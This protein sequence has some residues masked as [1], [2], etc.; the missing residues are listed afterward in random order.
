MDESQTRL[1]EQL[2]AHTSKRELPAA[3]VVRARGAVVRRRARRRQ[4]A[5]A[6]G[7]LCVALVVPLLV[8][9]TRDP[10]ERQTY[11]VATD[12][13]I[14]STSRSV[15]SAAAQCEGDLPVT[16]D[17]TH[18]FSPAVVNAP[19]ID[20]G[21]KT[22]SWQTADG[23][24]VDARW[25]S[26]V[27]SPSGDR[28][29]AG[30]R[31]A[32]VEV[33]SDS[34]MRLVYLT[35]EQL[36]G[37]CATVSF[38]ATASQKSVLD[39]SWPILLDHLA[40][41]FRVTPNAGPV[42]SPFAV[43]GA[44][45]RFTLGSIA[46]AVQQGR[47]NGAFLF[48]DKVG[49]DDVLFPVA[50]ELRLDERSWLRFTGTVPD[51]QRTGS[52]AFGFG[53]RLD[54]QPGATFNVTNTVSAP[55]WRTVTSPLGRRVNPNT[56][57]TGAEVLVWGGDDGSGSGIRLSGALFNPITGSWRSIAPSPFNSS[58][59][60]AVWAQNRAVFA[61]GEMVA[62]YEPATNRWTTG[63]TGMKAKNA[64]LLVYTGTTVLGWYFEG[65][66]GAVGASGFRID[67]T[68]GVLDATPLPT[69]PRAVGYDATSLWTD[70]EWMIFPAGDS[71]VG[72]A[73]DPA[74][75]R[76]REL[77]TAPIEFV[78]RLIVWTGTEVIAYGIDPRRPDLVA[79][80]AYEPST[81]RWRSLADIRIPTTALKDGSEYSID[82][83]RLAWTGSL[84]LLLSSFDDPAR[85][86]Y[87]NDPHSGTAQP[88][89]PLPSRVEIGAPLTWTGSD[90]IVLL[91][92]GILGAIRLR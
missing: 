20:G 48:L 45:S 81:N 71:R 51:V 57:W 6:G 84:V 92:S 11:T 24:R 32:T 37:P 76:W 73:F 78:R 7:V 19:S 86:I 74:T 87:A 80:V 8:F 40:G 66:Q 63:A 65:L 60:S 82:V 34:P 2:R 27:N 46:S 50:G 12:A 38:T 75:N 56:M 47:P 62:N 85:A 70:R 79:S 15:D 89:P 52:Y 58:P 64:P 25:P 28:R 30:R 5:G 18:G 31:A 14:S 17:T 90:A 33:D 44:P 3:S 39:Q 53:D 91:Q 72:M 16:I 88:L 69:P 55:E 23:V 43:T 29:I 36:E 61:N 77:P 35:D 1:E 68:T 41:T 49:S 10:G 42:G 9:A 4:L 22:A 67:P 59:V 54:R 21:V 83:P 13:S 26:S